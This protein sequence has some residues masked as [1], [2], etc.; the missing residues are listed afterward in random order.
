MIISHI[1]GGLGNQMFQYAAG[2]AHSARTGSELLLDLSSFENYGLHNGYELN[3]VFGITARS[4]DQIDLERMLGWRKSHLVRKVMKFCCK[5]GSSKN[6]II[7]PHFH[8][9]SGIDEVKS[10]SYLDGYWQ[11]EK[12]FSNIKDAIK[13]DFIFGKN[14]DFINQKILNKIVSTTSVGLH[15]RRGDYISNKSAAKVL[16]LCDMEYYRKAIKYFFEKFSAPK[17]FIFSDD[18]RW[19]LEN[20][21]KI[22]NNFEVIYHNTGANS[23]IDMQLMASCKHNIIANSSFSWWSAWLN[24]NPEKIIIAPEKWFINNRFNSMDLYCDGWIIL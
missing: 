8:Y 12:Y 24:N 19:V 15:V 21:E 22:L 13:Q 2:R 3:R 6:L 20:F 7:E 16:N 14:L 5:G 4:S 1:L 9:W 11:S 17:F 23:Y 18:P 10:N